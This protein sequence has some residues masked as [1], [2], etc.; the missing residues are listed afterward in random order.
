M[1]GE[2]RKAGVMGRDPLVWTWHM[3]VLEGR[4]AD[5]VGLVQGHRDAGD[6]HCG[7]MGVDS[8]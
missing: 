8:L 3:L 4:S 6:G 5:W 2:V 7:G 1:R